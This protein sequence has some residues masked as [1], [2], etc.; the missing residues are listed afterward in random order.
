MCTSDIFTSQIKGLHERMCHAEQCQ[1]VGN[2]LVKRNNVIKAG[3]DAKMSKDR[4]TLQ[5]INVF[6]RLS[7]FYS[8]TLLL[9]LETSLIEAQ[10]RKCN[11]AIGFALCT[12]CISQPSPWLFPCFLFLSLTQAAGGGGVWLLLSA[13]LRPADQLKVVQLD[14]KQW[15]GTDPL[16]GPNTTFI[17]QSGLIFSKQRFS[18]SV[19]PGE[20]K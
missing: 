16:V 8:L 5:Q 19:I 14:V 7:R 20:M 12:R 3:K 11:P 13:G 6:T 9:S 2:Q 1:C 15:N 18:K 17:S 4:P 10:T